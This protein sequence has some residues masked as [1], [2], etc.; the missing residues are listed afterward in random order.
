MVQLMNTNVTVKVTN[1]IMQ[2]FEQIDIFSMLEY[3]EWVVY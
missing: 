2:I 1:L 3:T